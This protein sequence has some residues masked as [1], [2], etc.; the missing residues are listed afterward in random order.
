MN[1]VGAVPVDFRRV[2]FVRASSNAAKSNVAA[3]T[4]EKLVDAGYEIH[5]IGKPSVEGSEAVPQG[6]LSVGKQREQGK[7]LKLN[8]KDNLFPSLQDGGWGQLFRWKHVGPVGPGF[9]N[10]GNTC[11]LNSVLQCLSYVPVFAQLCIAEKDLPYSIEHIVDAARVE[12]EKR[13]AQ[14]RFCTLGALMD[15]MR[16]VHAVIMKRSTK[17]KKHRGSVSPRLFASNLRKITKSNLMRI[18]VQQDAHEFLRLFIDAL[19]R[20]CALAAGF[21]ENSTDTRLETTAIMQLFGG[22]VESKVCCEMEACRAS[23]SKVE[24]FL[25]LSLDVTDSRVRSVA[26]ALDSFLAKES[27]DSENCWNCPGCGDNCKAASKQLSIHQ[28][29]NVLVVHLKRFGFGNRGKKLRKTITFEKDMDL[30]EIISPP[31]KKG[32]D[33]YTLVGAIVHSGVTLDSGH[34]VSFVKASN[35]IWYELDDDVIRQVGLDTVLSQPAYILFYTRVVHCADAKEE[36]QDQKTENNVTGL[37]AFAKQFSTKSPGGSTSDSATYPRT[38]LF[39]DFL[40]KISEHPQQ[41]TGT[42]SRSNSLLLQSLASSPMTSKRARRQLT[43]ASGVVKK[44]KQQRGT[45]QVFVKSEVSSKPEPHVASKKPKEVVLGKKSIEAVSKKPPT[46]AVPS[47]KSMEAVVKQQQKPAK[48]RWSEGDERIILQQQGKR[49]RKHDGEKSEWQ[50]Y[51]KR[52]KKSKQ[53]GSKHKY[54]AWDEHLDRGKQK[55]VKSGAPKIPAGRKGGVNQ[56]Q[57]K[58]EQK[59]KKSF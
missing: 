16:A 7:L 8:R 15:H 44:N 47:R 6:E 1:I 53:S 59:N 48:K 14:D 18:G 24:P 58:Q 21:E 9:N 5:V 27:L 39:G 26:D 46:G 40:E 49:K 35:G 30:S 31:R 57:K 43:L 23:S 36:E 4:V 17:E 33:R 11:F 29:P 13:G 3:S 38:E 2:E 51:V 50:K 10:L 22:Y 25:D 28:L 56:F 54:D 34:Y 45:V 42:R 12:A 37:A 19:Q 20:T 41:E 52:T 55:K 32:S